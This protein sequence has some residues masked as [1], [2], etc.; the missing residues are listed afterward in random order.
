M[1]CTFKFDKAGMLTGWS[2][3]HT[4]VMLVMMNGS[5]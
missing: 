1:L 2:E 5:S 4:R 3:K